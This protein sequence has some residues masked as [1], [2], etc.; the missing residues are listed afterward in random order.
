MTTNN[1]DLFNKEIKRSF[2]EVCEIAISSQIKFVPKI[3][4]TFT[5]KEIID[6]LWLH[7]DLNDSGDMVIL[8]G[9]DIDIPIE[10]FCKDE[11]T[12]SL[13]E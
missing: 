13:S 10:A 4:I 3:S 9:L 8:K 5:D 1:K 11:W 7:V 2:K 12:I 6:D